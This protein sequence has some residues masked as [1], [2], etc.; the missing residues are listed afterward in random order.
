MNSFFFHSLNVFLKIEPLPH[1]RKSRNCCI[2]TVEH[3][4]V[5]PLIV[6]D[7]SSADTGILATYFSGHIIDSVGYKQLHDLSSLNIKN[8]FEPPETINLNYSF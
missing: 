2:Y 4:D 6:I 3:T 5:F 1:S 8:S 7:S